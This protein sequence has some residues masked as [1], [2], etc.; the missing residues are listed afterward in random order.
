MLL[1]RSFLREE[2]PFSNDPFARRS[3]LHATPFVVLPVKMARE[4]ALRVRQR[5][6]AALGSRLG[7]Y[8]LS[9]DAVRP[10][11]TVYLHLREGEV[12]ECMD[13]IMAAL[14]TAEFG[15]VSSLLHDAGAV[16]RPAMREACRVHG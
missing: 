2:E 6:H 11:C 8:R 13:R 1:H 10:V 12:G 4:P 16:D 5:L 15:R 3:A 7:T 14:P 9:V